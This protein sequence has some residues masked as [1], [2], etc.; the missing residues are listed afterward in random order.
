MSLR[1]VIRL[2]RIWT[3]LLN[4]RSALLQDAGADL[5]PIA[6][7]SSRP[8]RARPDGA[9]QTGTGKTKTEKQAA[10]DAWY[11]AEVNKGLADIEAGRVVSHEEAEREMKKHLAALHRKHG[12]KVAY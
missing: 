2:H 7:H 11:V 8:R 6:G 9:A 4:P 10:Y 1:H 12:K 3:P 5:D